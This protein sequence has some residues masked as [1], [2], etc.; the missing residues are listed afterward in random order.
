MRPVACAAG[1]HGALLHAALYLAA[2]PTD[3][4]V[5]PTDEKD[6]YRDDPH[7]EQRSS[8]GAA[9]KAGREQDGAHPPEHRRPAQPT[10][11]TLCHVRLPG[12]P[13]H[14]RC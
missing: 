9:P 14:Q 10:I 1:R 13:C 6:V 7:P 3:E 4:D 12:G 8:V 2:D 11:L 5:D